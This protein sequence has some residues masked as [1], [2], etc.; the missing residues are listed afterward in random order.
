MQK[1][2]KTYE[3]PGCGDGNSLPRLHAARRWREPGCTPNKDDAKA[4]HFIQ[5]GSIEKGVC[6]DARDGVIDVDVVRDKGALYGLPT[7]QRRQ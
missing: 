3:I 4:I 2:R 1:N 7:D 6:T 5:L